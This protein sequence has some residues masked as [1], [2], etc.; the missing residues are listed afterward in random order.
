[1]L[2]AI[3]EKVTGES[4]DSYLRRHVFEPAGM[5][6]TDVRV[7]T[8]ARVDGM[9]HG[10]MVVG[11]GGQPI[12]PGAQPAPGSGSQPTALVDN[13]ARPQIAN[14]SGGAY[15]TTRD[16]VRFAQALL[17]DRLLT[18]AMT[19]IVLT[20]RVNSP[21]PGGPPVDKYTYG[22]AYQAVNGVTFVGHNG[23]TPGYESQIDI[24]PRSRYVVVILT[25][26]DMTMV[27]AIRKSEQIVTGA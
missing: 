7:Y 8:P 6:D 21:Q 25:N 24:Y 23:G 15:S 14:P 4:Y 1:V 12:S 3:I 17:D 2:G 10:Y 11:R 9:A 13:S 5:T 22:F 19:R 20:P 18:P 16:L 27:P 26:Q